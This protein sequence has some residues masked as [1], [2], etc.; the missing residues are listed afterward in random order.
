MPVSDALRQKNNANLGFGGVWVALLIVLLGATVFWVVI[1]TSSETEGP[2]L[3]DRSEFYVASASDTLADIV[4]LGSDEWMPLKN[5]NVDLSV[6]PHWFRVAIPKQNNGI[7]SDSADTENPERLIEVSFANLDEINAWFVDSNCEPICIFEEYSA[8]DALNFEQR[9]VL[10]EQFIFPVPETQQALTLYLE[11]KTLGSLKIPI[12]LW[13]ADEYIRYSSSHRVFIGIF[14]GFMTAIALLNIF[15]FITSKNNITLYYTAYIICLSLTI[16][17]SQGLT[18]RYLW[19]ESPEWQQQAILFFASAMVYFSSSFTAHVLRIKEHSK[20]LNTFFNIARAVLVVYCFATLLLPYALLVES[21]APIIIGAMLLVFI[22]TAY[23]AIL[24]NVVAFYVGG[25]WASLVVSGVLGLA[26]SLNW[27]N[28]NLDPSYLVMTSSAIQTLFMALGLA[29]LFN[30]QNEQAKAAYNEASLQKRKSME[31]KKALLTLKKNTQEE[32]E[33]AI[34]ERTYELEIAI[35]ELN[36]ANH[37]LERK[38]SIDALTG[39]ANRRFYDKRVVAEAR[40]SRREKTSLAIAMLDI[41][42]FKNVNDTYGHQCGDEALK[43]FAKVVSSCL[44]R[45][46]DTVCRYGGEEFVLIL[47]NTDLDGASILVESIRQ[48]VECSPLQC[49]GHTINLTVSAGLSCRVIASD[50][51]HSLLHAFADKLLYEAKHSGRNKVVARAF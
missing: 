4:A 44:K 3:N 13:D 20:W 10:H 23:L 18:F 1:Q 14:Y 42:H 19:P 31:A 39:V 6:K 2:L 43:H 32:L 34:D 12:K 51:E 40:R 24:G 17:T 25:A 41:D 27:I 9:S 5:S 38:N 15:L 16:A 36:E 30:Q 48:K 33:Y 45:P 11:V 28:I 37:E 50:E 49:E 47:P 35:R 21:L 46:S 8:G 26:D 22:S 7:G 29:M